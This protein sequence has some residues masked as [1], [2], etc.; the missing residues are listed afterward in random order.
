MGLVGISDLKFAQQ[1][2]KS[3]FGYFIPNNI[4]KCE[5][6]A[7]II[8]VKCILGVFIVSNGGVCSVLQNECL[9]TDG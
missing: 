4:Q 9:R 7:V 8:R 1:W 6:F 2:K 3:R 5:I